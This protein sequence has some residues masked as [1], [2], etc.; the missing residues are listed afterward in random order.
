MSTNV[1]VVNMDLSFPS[2]VRNLFCDNLYHL[3][4]T[5]LIKLKTHNITLPLGLV[6]FI[7]QLP[8]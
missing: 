5:I 4:W 6:L 7:G 1:V 2:L 3:W 8:H